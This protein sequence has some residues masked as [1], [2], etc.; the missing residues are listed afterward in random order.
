MHDLCDTMY[1]LRMDIFAT[2]HRPNIVAG[3]MS[4]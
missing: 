2:K 1:G 3:H 4:M